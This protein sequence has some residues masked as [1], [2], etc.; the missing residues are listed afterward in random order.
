MPSPTPLFDPGVT[1]LVERDRRRVW[2][3]YAPMPATTDAVPVLGASG[4]R[5]HLADG[6]Q[7]VDGMSSWWAAIHGYRHP[8][9]DGAIRDQLD[10]MAHVMFG[11]L[12]HPP[13]IE[14]CEALVDLAPRGLEH[15][16]LADS[17][18]VSIEVAIKMAIQ[19]WSGRGRPDRRRLLTVRS[20]YHGDTLGA[21]SV[22]DPENGMHHLFADVMPQQIFAAPPTPA[23]DQ[24]FTSSHVAEL[25]D[26]LLAHRGE[27][28]AV[29]LEPVVQGAGGMRFYSPDY[30]AAVR[31]LCDEHDVLLIA[32]EIATGFGRTGTMWGC[33]HAGI[34]PD[35]MCVGKALTGGYMTM[36][37]T[38]CTPEVAEGVSAAE[39]GALM[40]G[41]TFMGN[42]LGC[43][44]ASASIRLLTSH[45]WSDT[46]AAIEESLRSGLTPLQGAPG[47]TDVRVLGAIGVVEM[48][49]SIP[50]DVA[51]QVLLDRGVWLRPFGRLLYTMP[52]YVCSEPD[53]D[54][55]TAAMT[56]VVERVGERSARPAD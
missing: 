56:A 5:L 46:V 3:P 13:A 43:A 18:S 32:D 8:V 36:A 52:P 31:S 4:T 51:Q 23:F 24:P 7:V 42:P 9:L 26:L 1:D 14:V 16:F 38:L 49:D 35:I 54:A 53:L 40:H 2:H 12:T 21:M 33:D 47:V 22:C 15:V 6:R 45:S 50:M 30:L 27:V 28:A 10:R 20:G 29:I 48:D 41:P 17:G 34:A 19:Y 25:D 11:G 37:A 55:I 44:V 39:S